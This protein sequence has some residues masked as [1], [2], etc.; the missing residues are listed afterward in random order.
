MKKSVNLARG[1]VV[2]W[3]NL[4][5]ISLSES[6][7]DLLAQIFRFG[8]VGVIS[9]LIDFIFLYVFRDLCRLPLILSNT[10]A[11]CISVIYNYMASK[12]FV[13]NVDNS[14]D[15][16]KV[17]IKFIIFSVIGLGISNILMEVFTNVI[18]WY[19]LVA[20]VV[21]TLIVMI[22]NFV[23]RKKFLE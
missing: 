22:F 20:K 23:T 3:L 17:F 9:T 19:Y 1:I 4:F 6:T 14:K 13:F 8:I 5:H 21:A 15:S 7:I 16:R 18:N 10:L 12:T 2:F 11:F